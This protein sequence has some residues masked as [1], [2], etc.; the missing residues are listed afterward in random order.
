MDDLFSNLPLV[1]SERPIEF[2]F[3]RVLEDGTMLYVSQGGRQIG[4]CGPEVAPVNPSPLPEKEQELPTNATS[5]LRCEGS[6]ASATLQRSLASKLHLLLDV[7]GSP[8]YLLTWKNWDM[9]LREPISRLQALALR[10]A[11]NGYSG[12]PTP[13][14][15]DAKGYSEALKHKFR[16]TGHLKHWVHGTPLAVHSKTGVS[17]WPNPQLV[18]WMMGY[19]RLWI[20]DR[21]YE[22]TAT[23]SSRKSQPSSSEPS[24][25]QSSSSE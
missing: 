7:N 3:S 6:L 23:P 4:Q 20:S 2:T 17:S 15:M 9:P 10:T 16:K 5:G 22:P 25:K 1:T 12:L 13:Q 14:C 11:D 8:E 24:L 18:E 21:D 19:P